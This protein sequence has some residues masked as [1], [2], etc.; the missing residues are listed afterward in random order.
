[1][2]V[3]FGTIPLVT[4][5]VATALRIERVGAGQVIGAVVS[6]AGIAV[7]AVSTS[8]GGGSTGAWA[9]AAALMAVLASVNYS[10]LVREGA[11]GAHP[12]AVAAV[13]L[14][15]TTLVV[16]VLA[17]REGGSLPWPLPLRPTL[18]TIYLAVFGSVV[19]FTCYFYL[20]ERVP[21]MVANSLVLVQPLIALG[22]DAA[23]EHKATLGR[24][25]WL[26]VGLTLVGVAVNWAVKARRRPAA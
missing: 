10:V 6:L 18:A 14:T 1:M 7:I 3:L 19:A 5:L 11:G 2:A 24:A 20:L 23:F 25:T 13:F 12:L 15:V 16:W 21:L 9:L 22:V 17:W 26:G 4:A 8:D